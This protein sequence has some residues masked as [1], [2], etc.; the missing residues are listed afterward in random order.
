MKD[1]ALHSE[2]FALSRTPSR[3]KRPT[4]FFNISSCNF[5]TG[6]GLEHIDFRLFF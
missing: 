3:T 6:Y 5:G 2:L 1:G 4:Y